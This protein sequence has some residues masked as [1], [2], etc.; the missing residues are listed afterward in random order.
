[1]RILKDQNRDHIYQF[2]FPKVIVRV[3]LLLH[4]I[5]ILEKDSMLY[6]QLNMT[7]MAPLSVFE[8]EEIIK[9]TGYLIKALRMESDSNTKVH[10]NTKNQRYFLIARKD[11]YIQVDTEI[12]GL[13]DETDSLFWKNHYNLKKPETSQR[14]FYI[15]KYKEV[16]QKLDQLIGILIPG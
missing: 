10:R 7:G 9:R 16:F 13:T 5:D 11:K 3:N 4:Q 6:G 1:M 2:D 14:E 15:G 12:L 8:E